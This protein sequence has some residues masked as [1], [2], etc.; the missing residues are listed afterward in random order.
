MNEDR[1]ISFA[2]VALFAKYY[3]DFYNSPSIYTAKAD[4]DGSGTLTF[5]DVSLFISLY[6]SESQNNGV[7]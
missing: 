6:A 5:A 4:L 2:D 7:R 1:S 3:I